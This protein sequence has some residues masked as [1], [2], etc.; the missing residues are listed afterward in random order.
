MKKLKKPKNVKL[1]VAFFSNQPGILARTEKFLSKKFGRI[2]YRSNDLDFTETDYYNEE[3]GNGLK[4][5]FVSFERLVKRSS[6]PQIKL[7]SIKL[8]KKFSLKNGNLEKRKVNIDPGLLSMENFILATHKPYSHRIYL[9]KGIWADLT[10]IFS[11]TGFSN[12]P[13]TYPNYRS[14]NVKKILY[15]IRNLYHK[16]IF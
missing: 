3:M 2:D 14:E 9:K 13:W 12:L 6:L 7:L 10:L 8:E 1:V 4:M 11:K 5:R 15:Q 16:Q